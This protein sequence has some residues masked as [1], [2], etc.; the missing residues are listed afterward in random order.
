MLSGL[1]LQW[2]A[3][4]MKQLSTLTKPRRAFW[5]VWGWKNETYSFHMNQLISA[6][7][8][9]QPELSTF[10]LSFHFERGHQGARTPWQGYFP[11]LSGAHLWHLT[12][13]FKHPKTDMIKSWCCSIFTLKKNQTNKK[14]WNALPFNLTGPNGQAAETS[15]IMC[16]KVLLRWV[17]FL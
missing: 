13:I 9:T 5:F 7:F 16:P 10:K 3:E 1:S 6:V 12:R 14:H 15:S 17:I 8:T 2:H 4:K 11:P